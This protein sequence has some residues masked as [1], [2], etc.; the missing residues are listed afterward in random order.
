MSS[1]QLQLI[2]IEFVPNNILVSRSSEKGEGVLAISSDNNAIYIYR[3]LITGSCALTIKLLGQKTFSSEFDFALQGETFFIKHLHEV[4]GEKR[5]FL[6]K[7]TATDLLKFELF[8]DLTNILGINLDPSYKI[9]K[10]FDTS[11]L[12][13]KLFNNVEVYLNRKRA[14]LEKSQEAKGSK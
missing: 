1:K 7:A 6:D 12:F 2:D 13:K 9:F 8:Y 11:L 3:Y 4:D 10:P 14:R 5:L